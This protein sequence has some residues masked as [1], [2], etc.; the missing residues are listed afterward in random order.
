MR[1]CTAIPLHLNTAPA[2]HEALVVLYDKLFSFL[3][4]EL[5][6]PEIRTTTVSQLFP[7]R[8][9]LYICD[10]QQDCICSATNCPDKITINVGS[11]VTKLHIMYIDFLNASR[12]NRA[13]VTN[14]SVA[15]AAPCATHDVTD[16][17]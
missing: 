13:A 17:L 15:A 16:A 4:T 7:P 5:L 2:T 6:W 8:N 12:T 3:L 11:L 10:H 14:E 1:K 9:H